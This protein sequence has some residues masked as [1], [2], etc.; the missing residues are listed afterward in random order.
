MR[1]NRIVR[2]SAAVAVLSVMAACSSER[3]SDPEATGS[4]DGGGT[5]ETVMFGDMESPCGE[6]T[7]SGAT[8]QGV[9]EDSITIGYGDD[10]GYTAAPG[11]SQEVGDAVTA[12][13]DWCNDQGGINGRQLVGNQYDA[14]ITNTVQV[15]K[16]ACKSDFMLVGD[17]FANDFAGDPVRLGC[18]LPHV[19]A[20]TVGPNAT[21]GPLKIEP[22]PY[23]V[24]FY[25]ASGLKQILEVLP[26]A[27]KSFTITGTDA[28][29]T[30]VSNYKVQAAMAQLGHNAKDCGVVIHMAGDASYAPLAKKL[31]DCGVDS[32][33]T[34]YTPSPQIFGFMQALQQNKTEIP[35]FAESQ[36]YGAAGAEWN[37]QTGAADGLVV[38]LFVQPLENADV[39]DAVAAY[40]DILDASG[41]KTGMTGEFATSAFLLWAQAAKDCGS[42]LPGPASWASSP[43]STSGPPVVSRRRP[44]R[45]TTCPA[46]ARW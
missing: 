29:A 13:I 8:D 42:E 38:P 28:P 37:G 10:R 3:S 20:F 14:A 9:T 5:A 32:Y 11:L 31:A 16:K 34:A 45:A 25:N 12:M 24:D 46:T 23:P 15:L 30:Q 17:G 19:P 18:G 27:G 4:A 26:E 41:G 1:L 39:N 2:A 22:M 43:T 7:A 6:G 40:K 33:F 21:M 44:T 35:V 36:W